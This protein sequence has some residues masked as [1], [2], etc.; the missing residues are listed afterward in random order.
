M[1]LFINDALILRIF[2]ILH[3]GFPVSYL[4]F[5]LVI[6]L[7]S[8]KFLTDK[9]YLVT[10]SWQKYYSQDISPFTNCGLVSGIYVN[11]CNWSTWQPFGIS[12]H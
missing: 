12:P 6:S 2:V 9:K 7:W 1:L 4:L 8:G 10:H 11:Q 5:M 3:I